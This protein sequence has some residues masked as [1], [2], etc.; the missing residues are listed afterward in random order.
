MSQGELRLPDV[1]NSHRER[2]YTVFA[3]V[4]LPQTTASS[5]KRASS[6]G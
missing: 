6:L 1:S 5:A 4:G 3:W 2:F